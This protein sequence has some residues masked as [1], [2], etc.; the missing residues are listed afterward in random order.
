MREFRSVVDESDFTADEI[1][2]GAETGIRAPVLLRN[3]V[4]PQAARRIPQKYQSRY[5]AAG[6]HDQNVASDLWKGE[7]K[8]EGKE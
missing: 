1:A 4:N 7:G 5:K 6:E 2:T 3:F 8:V